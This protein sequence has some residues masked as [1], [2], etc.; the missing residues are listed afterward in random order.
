MAGWMIEHAICPG[1]V[2]CSTAVRTRRTLDLM[3][4]AAVPASAKV[5][6]RDDL[7]L[8]EAA[9]LVEM[10]QQVPD[11]FG[12]VMLIGHDPGMHD[13]AQMLTGAGDIVARRLLALKFPTAG[14]VVIDFAVRHWRTL[15]PGT[16]TLR[17]FM[18]P[19]RL[20]D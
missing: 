3:Q 19:K 5:E 9:D 11:E 18:S 10:V 16:G 2:F 14:V 4:P 13:M 8:A 1:L 15:A 12:H 6:L 17:H 20:P 7:Y